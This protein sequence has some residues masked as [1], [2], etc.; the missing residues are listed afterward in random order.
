M[1]MYDWT[2]T[3]A[4]KFYGIIQLGQSGVNFAINIFYIFWL[5]KL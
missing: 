3:Q 1:T 5:G 2:N 4:V